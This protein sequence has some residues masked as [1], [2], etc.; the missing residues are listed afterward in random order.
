MTPLSAHRSVVFVITSRQTIHY[1]AVRWWC[2]LSRALSFISSNLLH[3]RFCGFMTYYNSCIIG[4]NPTTTGGPS[5][6]NEH[7]HLF[8]G[9]SNPW[10]ASI[11]GVQSRVY[12]G[13]AIV[14]SSTAVSINFPVQNDRVR[15]IRWR[16]Q[17]TPWTK[18][19]IRQKRR[20]I[21]LCLEPC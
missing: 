20:W 15:K 2:P 21:Y 4:D 8:V 9:H 3:R 14:Y 1:V 10:E 17:S 7:E 12:H 16:L 11:I 18:K 5:R 6:R 19:T 13:F